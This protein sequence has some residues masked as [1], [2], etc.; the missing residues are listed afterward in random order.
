LIFIH[1][2]QNE[3][4]RNPA[5]ITLNVSSDKNVA[6]KYVLDNA[7]LA[8]AFTSPTMITNL[9]NNTHN[10][11][12]RKQPTT[13]T[14]KVPIGNDNGFTFCTRVDKPY[15][16]KVPKAPAKANNKIL[17]NINISRNYFN[18]HLST[19]IKHLS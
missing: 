10:S 13:L 17:L 8:V 16:D 7:T 6:W 4:K 15:L 2:P 18:N 5:N 9:S 3:S 12:A 14:A 19:I 11:P 1:S